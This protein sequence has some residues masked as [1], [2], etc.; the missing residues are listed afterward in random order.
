MDL[1]TP[2]QDLVLVR[3]R[4]EWEGKNDSAGRVFGARF[5]DS[6]KGWLAGADDIVQ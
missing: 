5:L 3:A 4:V 2:L 1:E 6:S